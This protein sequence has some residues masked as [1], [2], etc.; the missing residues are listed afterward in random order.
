[1]GYGTCVSDRAN[2][3]RAACRDTPRARAMWFH[4][5]PC[6]LATSTAPEA[7]LRRH[8]PRPRRLR[9]PADRPCRGDSEGEASALGGVSTASSANAWSK[10][11][12]WCSCRAAPDVDS[13]QRRSVDG[14]RVSIALLHRSDYGGLESV[15]NRRRAIERHVLIMPD[16]AAALQAIVSKVPSAD[17]GAWSISSGVARADPT[18]FGRCPRRPRPC[19]RA[20]RAVR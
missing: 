16:A 12:S 8:V 2:R 15:T 14:E 13:R 18:D 20:P 4:D 10:P 7:G 11:A 1:M 17:C 9:P 6:A 5:L 3:C 19:R